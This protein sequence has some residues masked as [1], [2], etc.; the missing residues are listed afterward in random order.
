VRETKR[1]TVEELAE[2]LREH[3]AEVREG[4]TI[5]VVDDGHEVVHISPT[6]IYPKSNKRLADIIPGPRPPNLKTDSLKILM[7]DRHGSDCDKE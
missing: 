3:L 1:V 6:I 2:H 7:E 5:E 4:T